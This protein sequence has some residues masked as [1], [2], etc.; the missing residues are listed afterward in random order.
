MDEACDSA[1]ESSLEPCPLSFHQ[2]SSVWA[3]EENPHLSGPGLLVNC[4]WCPAIWFSL[5]GRGTPEKNQGIGLYVKPEKL[6]RIISIYF[7]LGVLSFKTQ[8]EESHLFIFSSIYLYI[9]VLIIQQI[10]IDNYSVPGI[11]LGVQH[12]SVISII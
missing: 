3:S 5:Q 10:F 1:L 2:C 11:V 9:H 8:G 6:L 12:I 7:V 4:F